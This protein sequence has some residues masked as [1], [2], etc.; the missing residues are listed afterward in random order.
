MTLE[1]IMK[2]EPSHDLELEEL[3]KSVR[4]VFS[5]VSQ[6]YR[7]KLV[8]KLLNTIKTG[9]RNEFYWNV[10]RVLN[11]NTDNPETIKIS[12]K[13]LKLGILSSKDF[14]KVAYAVIFGIISVRGGKNE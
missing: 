8:Y 1:K 14:E 5:S 11:A 9:D 4:V 10:A 12:E 6:N 7:Q 3:V 13:L 2:N